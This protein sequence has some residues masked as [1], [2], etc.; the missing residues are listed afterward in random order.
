MIKTKKLTGRKRILFRADNLEFVFP[1]FENYRHPTQIQACNSTETANN[2]N[3]GDVFVPQSKT[4]S[5]TDASTLS[6]RSDTTF[7]AA[8]QAFQFNQ[9][10][11]KA[12]TPKEIKV[13]YDFGLNQPSGEHSG[14]D[15]AVNNPFNGLDFTGNSSADTKLFFRENL[16]ENPLVQQSATNILAHGFIPTD[17]NA[18]STIKE[19]IALIKGNGNFDYALARSTAYK[20]ENLRAP[21]KESYYTALL[22]QHIAGDLLP[23]VIFKSSNK[24]ST[25]LS[26]KYANDMGVLNRSE[27]SARERYKAV[28]K[29]LQKELGLKAGLDPL[30]VLSKD[31]LSK[32]GE[33]KVQE[34]DAKGEIIKVDGKP[35]EILITLG[36]FERYLD[37]PTLQKAIEKE[38]NNR[39]YYQNNNYAAVIDNYRAKNPDIAP[40][41]KVSEKSKAKLPQDTK[42][43]L[44]TLV[45]TINP[46]LSVNDNGT[47]KQLLTG[48]GEENKQKNKLITSQEREARKNWSDYKDI[49]WGSSEHGNIFTQENK[50]LI[51]QLYAENIKEGGI[52][53]KYLDQFTSLMVTLVN[54]ASKGTLTNQEV[55]F[56]KKISIESDWKPD[57]TS[58]KNIAREVIKVLGDSNLKW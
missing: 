52:D 7:P 58:S 33:I 18:K 57:G 46:L 53:V 38:I 34:R 9:D 32:A 21:S 15:F 16:A 2:T 45:G 8:S 48:S 36:N 23:G 22:D 27:V 37:D 25:E 26:E 1:G 13:N 42:Q 43:K 28:S 41:E 49:K 30:S 35:K 44:T 50:A 56:L 5:F 24:F 29:A 14:F 6:F 10:N 11:F 12:T 51:D 20:T 47:T 54:K 31:I 39:T 40:D 17:K 55:A 3:S 19:T 4:G